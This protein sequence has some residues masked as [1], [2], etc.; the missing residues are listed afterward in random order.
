MHR[1]EFVVTFHATLN[2]G[3]PNPKWTSATVRQSSDYL[4]D[5]FAAFRKAMHKAG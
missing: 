3:R 5:T 2:N 1:Y 4:V